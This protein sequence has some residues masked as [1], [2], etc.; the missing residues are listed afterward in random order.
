MSIMIDKRK[1]VATELLEKLGRKHALLGAA[2]LKKCDNK[3]KN[4]FWNQVI[5][6][7]KELSKKPGIDPE[8][9]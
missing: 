7:I 5:E 1:I 8:L 9:T 2:R 3:S 6:S 4:E